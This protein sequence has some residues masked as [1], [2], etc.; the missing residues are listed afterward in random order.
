M[1]KGKQSI[2]SSF[3][4][5]GNDKAT[6]KNIHVEQEYLLNGIA[7]VVEMLCILAYVQCDLKNKWKT[8]YYFFNNQ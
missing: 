6:R 3:A 4:S 2:I 5:S 8:L 1:S 7:V